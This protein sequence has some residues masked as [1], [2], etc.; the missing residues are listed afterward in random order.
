MIR[1]IVVDYVVPALIATA[2]IHTIYDIIDRLKRIES[3][4]NR[5]DR[6]DF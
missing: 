4:L 3:H 6:K 2:V 5:L 1:E